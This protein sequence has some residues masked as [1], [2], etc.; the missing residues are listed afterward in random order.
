MNERTMKL[1]LGAAVVLSVVIIFIFLTFLG[2]REKFSVS[3][4]QIQIQMLDAPNVVQ[5]TPI[6]QSGILIGRVASVV[7][8]ED[9]G[10]VITA[11]IYE[12]HKLYHD[13]ECRLVSTLLGDA[14]LR[15]VTRPNE[16]GKFE[17][18]EIK[19]GELIQGQTSLDPS[20]LVARM[21]EKL[22]TA[23]DDVT[24]ASAQL[25]NVAIT[26]NAMLNENRENVKDIM[27]NARSITGNS[28]RIVQSFSVI[29]DDEF[30]TNVQ[31]SV[32]NLR[33]AS[34]KLPDAL[35]QAKATLGELQGT[36]QLSNSAIQKTTERLDGSLDGVDK[37]MTTLN[38]TLSNVEKIT[39]PL[40]DDELTRKWLSNI[41][42]ILQNMDVFTETLNRHDSTLGLLM[43]D[44]EMYDR[45]RSTME[46]VNELPRQLEPIIFNAKVMTEK[47]A[48]HPELLGLRGYL[49]KDSGTSQ[50]IPWPKGVTPYSTSGGYGFWPEWGASISNSAPR[51]T[52][53]VAQLPMNGA[54]SIA[55]QA[56]TAYS[57]TGNSQLAQT[58]ANS[59]TLAGNGLGRRENR[60]TLNSPQTAPALHSALQPQ[61]RSQA[62]AQPQVAVTVGNELKRAEA[63][64]PVSGNVSGKK[65][66]RANIPADATE[67]TPEMLGMTPEEFQKADVQVLSDT[68]WN[69]SVQGNGASASVLKTE[70][71]TFLEKT[72]PDALPPIVA[73]P[74]EANPS[75]G[76][77]FQTN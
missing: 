3:C 4:Y 75:T 18:T 7:L 6:Y 74:V 66:S 39:Q 19:P 17:H 29:L 30:C 70:T 34:E 55:T 52:P 8:T 36:I 32:A 59:G 67:I 41:T 25:T 21:Q 14:S 72:L 16:D 27:N 1:R 71:S 10:V 40:A 49:K 69:A 77:N 64:R 35:D 38:S 61:I 31:T 47:L 33:E 5:N 54:Q 11:N 13:Q 23:I 62:F 51:S 58:Q 42:N 60:Q 28:A 24:T 22:T 56:R 53:L 76:G 57:Q 26:T 46:R 20:V 9:K 12:Q 37:M 45:L 73:Q 65:V 48:Q 2:S 68:V 63:P 50:E 43:T 15:M 44:R